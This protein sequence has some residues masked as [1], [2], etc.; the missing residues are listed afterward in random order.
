MRRDKDAYGDEEIILSEHDLF[1]FAFAVGYA[2]G[3]LGGLDAP[4]DAPTVA[5]LKEVMDIL[6]ALGK[7]NVTVRRVREGE[8]E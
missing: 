3:R 8:Q 4:Q 1:R 7:S 5:D 6:I 2:Q